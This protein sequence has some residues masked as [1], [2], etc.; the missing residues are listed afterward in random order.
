MQWS[1]CSLAL[2][3]RFMLHIPRPCPSSSGVPSSCVGPGPPWLRSPSYTG[4]RRRRG[5]YYGSAA[6][7]APETLL[8]RNHYHRWHNG[9]ASHAGVLPVCGSVWIWKIVDTADKPWLVPTW[10][11][12]TAAVRRQTNKRLEHI[13][14]GVQY[15]LSFTAGVGKDQL[16]LHNDFVEYRYIKLIRVLIQ[17]SA[18]INV[19]HRTEMKTEWWGNDWD[20]CEKLQRKNSNVSSIDKQSQNSENVIIQKWGG[21]NMVES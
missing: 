18:I 15:Y 6:C 5:G 21:R 16:T 13:L 7:A 14:L 10:P 4:S 19:T 9:S 3:H 11:A 12:P 17:M 8:G 2:S 20:W 1:Y